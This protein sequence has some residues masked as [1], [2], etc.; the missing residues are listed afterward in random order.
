MIRPNYYDILNIKNT[1]TQN[2]IKKAYRKLAIKYHPDKPNGNEEKFKEIT[3][4]YEVLSDT[5]K[6]SQ[7]DITGFAEINLQDPIEI[8][9]NLFNDFQPDIFNNLSDGLKS[10]IKSNINIKTVVFEDNFNEKINDAIPDMINTFK[11]VIS[12]EKS[13]N[14]LKDTLMNNFIKT[15][16]SIFD[17]SNNSNS[18][19]ENLNI[20]DNNSSSSE[21]FEL[22]KDNI[23]KNNINKSNIKK[24]SK[25]NNL[26]TIMPKDIK[27]TKNFK[28]SDFY[29]Q[30]SKIFSYN[31]IKC[32]ENNEE[33]KIKEK[34]EVPL[35]LNKELCIKGK[36]HHRKKYKECGNIYFNF[37][38]IEDKNFKVIQNDLYYDMMINISELYGKIKKEIILLDGTTFLF[39]Y[40][41]LYK[42]D[43][44]IIEKNLGLPI[45]D[46]EKRG[47]LH[48]NIKL[49]FKD[50]DE[51]K[52]K[53]LHNIFS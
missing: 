53:Q 28:L 34:I 4:A 30:K 31:R 51:E 50:L 12:G 39:E 37:N 11:N 41:N 44:H 5:F 10:N 48:I 42:T 22:D 47:D 26:N 18:L 38:Y 21:D 2:E 27:I 24:M 49:I 35:V 9:E 8:F 52:I 14:P 32:N 23:N 36:G 20:S 13:D 46:N 45:K 15:T 1:C 19:F 33:E 6:R 3:E 43:L 40:E 7:Y 17:N 25:E 29:N 16:S